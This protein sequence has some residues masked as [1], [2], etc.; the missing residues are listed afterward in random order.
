MYANQLNP[1]AFADQS[2]GN[3]PI[4]TMENA[5]SSIDTAAGELSH[6]V[7][8]LNA[9]LQGVIAPSVPAPQ[10]QTK[11]ITAVEPPHSPAVNNLHTLRG[12][13]EALTMLV[14]DMSGRLET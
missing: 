8:N 12:R 1:T 3:R 6:A 7:D 13:L 2:V 9:R 5:L 4:S 14:N 10:Q 11:G